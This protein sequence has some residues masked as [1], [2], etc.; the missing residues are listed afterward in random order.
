MVFMRI[1][2][3]Q[4]FKFAYCLIVRPCGI[5]VGVETDIQ[6]NSIWVKLVIFLRLGSDSEG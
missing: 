5:G 3:L 4:S 6:K 1:F 2:W